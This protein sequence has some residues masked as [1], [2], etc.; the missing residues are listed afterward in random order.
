[1]KIKMDA[2]TATLHEAVD[3]RTQTAERYDTL[4]DADFQLERAR[5]TL[6]RATGGLE[7]WAKTAK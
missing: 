1:V 4:Q 3:A 5:I 6:L 7:S 2:G